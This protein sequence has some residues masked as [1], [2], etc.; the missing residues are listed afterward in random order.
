MSS[1]SNAI[2]INVISLDRTPKRFA[3]FLRVN[4][5]TGIE[6]VKISAIDG[7][8]LNREDLIKRNV[9]AQDLIFTDGAIGC[10]LTHMACWQH[11]I[12]TGETVIV[13]EDDAVFRS[14][15]LSVYR[16]SIGALENHDLLYLGYNLDMSVA[17]EMPGYGLVTGIFSQ[18]VATTSGHVAAFRSSRSAVNVY[19]VRRLWGSLCY[20]VT[21]N[22]ARKLLEACRPL[23][24]RRSDRFRHFDG[25]GNSRVTDLTS[26]G[27]DV[28]MSV[29]AME[30]GDFLAMVPPIVMSANDKTMSTIPDHGFGHGSVILGV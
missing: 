29:C 4:D 27:I 30:N 11:A 9:I 3:E 8:V 18:F 22:G 16:S 6:I 2:R 5:L 14:D 25:L 10:A 1:I 20:A 17:Y 26:T 23:R 28:H 7:Q 15:F 13:C 24:N 19:R 12:D 21:P